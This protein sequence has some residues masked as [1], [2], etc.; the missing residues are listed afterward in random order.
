MCNF[1]QHTDTLLERRLL[2]CNIIICILQNTDLQH[3]T[4]GCVLTATEYINT[5]YTAYCFSEHLLCLCISR[6]KQNIFEMSVGYMQYL[7]FLAKKN[8]PKSD[9]FVTRNSFSGENIYSVKSIELM[10]YSKMQKSSTHKFVSYFSLI[11][12]VL[13]R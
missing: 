7:Q 3:G 10:Y 13:C 4:V 1:G 11:A 12:C 2:D 8:P 9:T 6:N 5:I